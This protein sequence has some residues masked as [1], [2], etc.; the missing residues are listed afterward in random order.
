MR[1]WVH[2]TTDYGKKG[3]GDGIS[4]KINNFLKQNYS[5]DAFFILM[6]QTLFTVTG[7]NMLRLPDH[8]IKGASLTVSSYQDEPTTRNHGNKCRQCGSGCCLPF[9]RG[10]DSSSSSPMH[11]SSDEPRGTQDHATAEQSEGH[12]N[13]AGRI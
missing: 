9:D 5:W 12:F 3:K 4:C 13:Q 2:R 7:M 8:Y 11:A 10:Q 1:S 6:Q